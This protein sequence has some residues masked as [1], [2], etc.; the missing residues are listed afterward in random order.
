M[1][2]FSTAEATVRLRAAGIDVQ[3]WDVRRA[4]GRM[5]I[6]QISGRIVYDD[7]AF[8]M[9]LSYFRDNPPKRQKK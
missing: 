9:I 5:E 8:E 6:P 4:A 7:A 2:F 1:R 3:E